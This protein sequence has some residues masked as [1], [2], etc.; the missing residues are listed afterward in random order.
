MQLSYRNHPVTILTCLIWSAITFFIILFN[1]SG[2]IRIIFG[3][4][5]VLFIPGYI[6]VYTLFPSKKTDEGIDVIERIAL[7]LGLSLAV[8]PLIGLGLNYTPWGIRLT[9]II[10]SLEVFIFGLGSIA[11]FRWYQLPKSK[12]FTISINLRFPEHENKLDK[13]LT[14]I[15]VVSIIIAASLLIYVII[16][17]KTGEKFTEFY[18]LG[19][20]GIADNYPRNLTTNQ[21]ASVQI[22]IVNHEYKTVNYT[23]EIWLV[24]QT[25]GYNESSQKNETIYHHAWYIESIQT[26]LNHTPINIEEQWQPQWE[27]NYTF[28]LN[29]TGEYK[30][31]FLL[32][33]D[34]NKTYNQTVDYKTIAESKFDS[35]Q[36]DAYRTVHLWLT[37]N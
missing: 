24:N 10:L 21:N 35:D 26:T 20:D 34:Y 27:T 30:L 25:F 28:S 33:T 6:L 2:P 12:R 17:P 37:I 14:L 23:I 31:A 7:S 5:I 8:V 29:K 22:G 18:I 4:P 1:I 13:A 3:L 16:T 36:T 19:P 15:L 11:M 9:P 32:Y